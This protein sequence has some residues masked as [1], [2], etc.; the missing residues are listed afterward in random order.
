MSGVGVLDMRGIRRSFG[1]VEALG[2]IDLRVPGGS[3]ITLLGPSGCGKTTLLRVIA[4]F[5]HA[6]AGQVHLDDLDLLPLPPERRPIN[7]VF[8]RYALFPHLDVRSNVAFGLQ[9][10]GVPRGDRAA[11]VAE[12]LEMVRL[13]GYEKRRIDQLSGG[14]QQRVAL[15]RAIVNRPKLLLLDEPLGALDL[16]LRKEMQLELRRLHREIGSTFIYVTHDQ[17]EALVMSDRIVVM[18]GGGIE[19][20]G[21]PEEIYSHP[22][23]RFVAGFVGETNILTGEVRAGRFLQADLGLDIPLPGTA[24]GAV[25]LSIRPEAVSLRGRGG[26]V[27]RGVVDDSI[28]IG[29]IVRHQVRLAD[30]SVFV[31]QEPPAD[32]GVRQRGE[33]VEA[34]WA[35]DDAVV[36]ER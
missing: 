4:G 13:T 29:S 8:Q 1:E 14:Q 24:D 9:V 15:A 25:A 32:G 19:Q 2:G 11:R 31:V 20:Q 35:M 10:A 3:F 16:Q 26:T 28:F 27:L 36:L 18:R 34:S 5:E 22:V 33:S 12:A 17:E 23:T 7:L 6:D 21:T 30:G